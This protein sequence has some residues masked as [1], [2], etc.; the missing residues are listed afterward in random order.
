MVSKTSSYFQEQ[1]FS[2]KKY[3]WN[4]LDEAY[5]TQNKIE[6]ETS[7]LQLTIKSV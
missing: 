4:F 7:S 5:T 3:N 1:Y 2:H 6:K